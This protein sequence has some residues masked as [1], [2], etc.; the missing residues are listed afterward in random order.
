MDCCHT[1][2][3]MPVSKA[4]ETIKEKTTAISQILHVPLAQAQNHIL[5]EDIYSPINI[6]PFANSAMD[7]YAVRSSDLIDTDKLILAGTAFAGQPF[8]NQ[9]PKGHCIRIMTGAKIPPQAD[10]VIMQEQTIKEGTSIRFLEKP[11]PQQHIRPLG[12]DIKKGELVLEK[13]TFLSARE[14]PMLATLGIATIAVMRKINVAFFSTGDELVQVGTKLEDGQIYDSNRYTLRAMLESSHCNVID[15][16]VVADCPIA[17]SKT[18]HHAAQCADLILSSGGVSVGEADHT[19]EVLAQEGQVDFWKIAIK[20][21]KPFAFGS[22]NN[23]LF[24]GLPGNPVSVM[25]TFHV[26]VRPLLAKLAGQRFYQAPL[27]IKAQALT[28]FKKS[29]GRE[30]Y[31]RAVYHCNEQ[32][33]LVV[34]SLN[35]QS[36]GAF[37]SL[38]KANCFAILEPERGSVTKGEMITIEPFNHF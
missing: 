32:G 11:S 6:P 18:M 14:I 7:G 24:C 23:T 12:E 8:N 28:G 17:L 2:D 30:D 1:S 15:L 22:I 27:K 19:K 4:I 35:N 5:G 9:W 33:E 3:L 13:G 31:Q 34:S 38:S 26:F 20:P 37:S 36:S 10:A 25:V 29:P 16:G 21:G